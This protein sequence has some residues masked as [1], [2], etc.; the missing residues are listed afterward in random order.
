MNE[1]KATRFHRLRRRAVVLTACWTVL[2]LAWL[3]ASGASAAL[4]S[5]A[6]G[7][8]HAWLPA[9]LLTP[10]VAAWCGFAIALIHEVGALP[11]AFFTGFVLERRFGLSRQSA[12]EW[13]KDHA[14]ALGLGFL[15]LPAAAAFVYATL[16]LW[17]EG[18][19][20][21]VAGGTV[22][23]SG[24]LAWLAPVVLLPLFFKAAPLQNAALRQRLTDMATR[25]G[26]PVTEIYEW[27]LSDRTSRANAALTGFGR[28]RRIL[29]SDTLLAEYS[30][31]EI[32][33]VLA[34]EL[35]H[36]VHHD[37]WRALVFEAVVAAAGLWTSARVFAVAVPW[38]GLGGAADVAGLPL[39]ALT[40]MTVSF[41]ALPVAN[42]FSRWQERRADRFAL[43][44]T[45]N[46]DAFI[47]A[48]RRL[49]A[50]N[51]AEDDP[52]PFA[53]IFFYTH[54]PVGDRLAYAKR[55]A[56]RQARQTGRRGT[57]PSARPST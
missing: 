50:R 28:T 8:L 46:P 6:Q 34:H 10:A 41:I 40:V 39:L 36:H 3:L 26:V 2:L 16:V 18:W 1:D 31:D 55:W 35:A 24:I 42:A 19:W 22:L 30:E 4:R 52:S 12:V 37:V 45:R 49:A 23:V 13:M 44:I 43:E 29:M 17:P 53:R 20:V 57:S 11:F 51:L 9:S 38:L 25:A 15:F 56:L 32:E 47:S 48:M 27:R 7:R 14:K 33:A 21:I 5:A 54:P